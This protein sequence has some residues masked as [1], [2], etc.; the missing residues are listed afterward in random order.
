MK[1][2]DFKIGTKIGLGFF[3][4]IVFLLAIGGLSFWSLNVLHETDEWETHTYEVLANI[5]R[6][7]AHLVDAETGQRRASGQ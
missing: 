4:I 1:L 6:I 5:E 7:T 2:R 3:V